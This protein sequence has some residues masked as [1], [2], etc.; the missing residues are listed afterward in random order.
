MRDFHPLEFLWS[1]AEILITF[2]GGTYLSIWL[3]RIQQFLWDILP[4]SNMSVSE[5]VIQRA[6][7]FDACLCWWG[8]MLIVESLLETGKQLWEQYQINKD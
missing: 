1:V 6:N 7:A 3:F 2:F 8:G 5:E 4:L